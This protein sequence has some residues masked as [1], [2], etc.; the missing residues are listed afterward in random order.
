MYTTAK[1]FS[2]NDDDGDND[3]DGEKKWLQESTPKKRV[4]PRKHSES[5]HTFDFDLERA[6]LRTGEKSELLC[7]VHRIVC[8]CDHN[9]LS[10]FPATNIIQQMKLHSIHDL[11]PET[12]KRNA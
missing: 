4:F 1:T 2:T 6:A 12:W 5:S 10:G 9:L 8:A 3:D 7:L 11:H